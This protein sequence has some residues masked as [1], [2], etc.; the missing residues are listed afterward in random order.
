M[1]STDSPALSLPRSTTVCGHRG[2]AGLAPE[3]TLPS[4]HK[5]VELG[6]RVLELDLHLSRDGQVVCLHDDRLD[7][8]TAETGPVSE[9]DWAELAGI[10]VLPGAFE[11]RYPE[12][13]IPLFRDVLVELPTNCRFLV[14]LKR[15]TQRPQALVAASLAVIV[16]AGA[17]ERCR[18]ISFEPEL[19]RRTRAALD[20]AQPELHAVTLGVLV[21]GRDRE[22]LLP[23]AREV[24]A[25]ALH[26]HHSLVDDAL[27]VEARAGGF[28]VST[29]TVNDAAR[30]GELAALGVDEVTADYPDRLLPTV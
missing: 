5:A 29:W 24:R 19:L 2:A 11:G 10:P 7:R 3:N 28:A 16:A 17:A 14:E 15:D 21:G 26:P 22:L 30:F 25:Q 18:I 13:R 6:V 20:A 23:L 4:F 12:A 27:L 1:P 8:V 9:R